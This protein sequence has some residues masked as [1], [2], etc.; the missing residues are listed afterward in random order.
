M[1]LNLWGKPY[2][3]LEEGVVEN[4]IIHCAFKTPLLPSG[5]NA[6]V[7]SQPPRND[8]PEPD[9]TRVREAS[10][11]ASPLSLLRSF[12]SFERALDHVVQS[13]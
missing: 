3:N 4:G 9:V 13:G 6:Q 5:H 7:T 2:S 1:I 8:A 11:V 12:R 10:S